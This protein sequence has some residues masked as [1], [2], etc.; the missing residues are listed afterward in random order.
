MI[1]T[2]A[3]M[4]LALLFAAAAH[5]GPLQLNDTQMDGVTA[6]QSAKNPYYAIT[7]D[8]ATLQSQSTG[9]NHPVFQPTGWGSVGHTSVSALRFGSGGAIA[10]PGNAG[11]HTN[12]KPFEAH[13][14]TIIRPP[15]HN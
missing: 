11:S 9:G 4:S 6:G 15:G 7:G 13:K 8:T 14:S 5:A 2:S 12:G 10:I 1:R 3:A